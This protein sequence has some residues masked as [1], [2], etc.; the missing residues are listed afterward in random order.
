LV[1]ASAGEITISLMPLYLGV[2]IGAHSLTAIV[3]QVDR[4]ARRIVFDRSWYFDREF[5]EYAAGDRRPLL[6]VDAIDRMLARLAAAAEIEIEHIRAIAGA[7]QEPCD[8]DLPRAIADAWRAITPAGALA[9]QLTYVFDVPYSAVTAAVHATEYLE[10]L[11]AGLEPGAHGGAD[12]GRLAG[13]WR[14]RYALPAATIVPWTGAVQ[15][16]MIGTGV[17][18]D[19]V[20]GVTLGATDTVFARG[21]VVVFRNGALA[22]EWLRAEYRLDW[23]A[24]ERI[25]DAPPGNGDAIML[26][27]LEAETTPAI[28][29][30]ALRRFGFDRHDAATNVRAL[31]EG[32][33]MAMANHAAAAISGPI[34]RI[35]ATGGDTVHRALLQ[36]MANVFGADVYRL[37]AGNAS[38]LGAALR[39]YHADQLASGEP[40]SWHNVIAGFTDPN[41]GHRVSP[42]PRMVAMYADRRRDYAMLERLHRDRPPIC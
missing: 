18:R 26:P 41:A 35:I 14:K 10:S 37:D 39:A 36:V 29:H 24:I 13:Y 12:A 38:A 40:L 3:I 33:L 30:P 8:F 34:D 4:D 23:A 22:R 32:Q 9:P 42:N 5:P 7:V 27:W 1:F 28:A 25:L 21:S 11:L 15:A 17:I 20:L 31:I 16:T 19:R 6:W 2:D